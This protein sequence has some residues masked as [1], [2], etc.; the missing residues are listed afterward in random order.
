MQ[1]GSCQPYCGATSRLPGVRMRAGAR[2]R[3][4]GCVCMRTCIC[5]AGDGLQRHRF[6]EHTCKHA[7]KEGPASHTVA[8]PHACQACAC[9][10]V[11]ARARAW[12]RVHAHVCACA[13][14]RVRTR[15]RARSTQRRAGINNF[16]SRR[17]YPS[18]RHM[19]QGLKKERQWYIA[20]DTRT[21][22]GKPPNK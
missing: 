9:V 11:H 5:A 1:R 12:V 3:V 2:A 4:L 8:R 16:L 6:Q 21:R 18:Y 10:H 20:C 15:A 14:A 22:R 13:R 7:C 19:K 17:E